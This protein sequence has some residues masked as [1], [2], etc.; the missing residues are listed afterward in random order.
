[1]RPA[2]S[3][4][5]LNS[6]LVG[7]FKTFYGRF[8]GAEGNLKTEVVD[9]NLIEI[10]DPRGVPAKVARRLADALE[11][12][13]EREVGRLVEEQLM[14]CHT[15]ECARKL[16]TAGPLAYS[17]ELR[18]PDRRELDDAVFQLLGVADP[19]E[20]SELVDRL[21]EATARHFRDIRVVE[22]EKM[23][24]RAKSN[25]RRLILAK[26]RDTSALFMPPAL[27]RN[28]APAGAGTGSF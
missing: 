25:S 23:G 21:Y 11:R 16:A 2:A 10:P 4:A 20:R 1:M 26:I 14:D 6:T 12:M 22:I 15:S 17:G 27:T 24:Q 19:K 3:Q 5:V 8:A 7:L 9:V 13:G 18:Q 28:H